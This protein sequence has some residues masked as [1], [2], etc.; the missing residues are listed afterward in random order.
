M[1]H[2]LQ[3]EQQFAPGGIAHIAAHPP[4]RDQ[5]LATC[6][7][8]DAMQGRCRICDDAAGR[9][10]ERLLAGGG[11]DDQLAAVVLLRGGKKQR[12]G[13]VGAGAGDQDIV[14]MGAVAVAARI[15]A[16][17]CPRTGRRRRTRS[18][19]SRSRA[20]ASGSCRARRLRGQ[21]RSDLADVTHGACEHKALQWRPDLELGNRESLATRRLPE[22][23]RV[24]ALIGRSGEI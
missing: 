21:Y 5:T 19:R 11:I 24:L 9:Q 17:G 18:G 6:D 7:R 2:G 16:R 3:I 15:W 20:A 22:L 10:L 12:E 1:T 23:R 4:R 14:N 8:G 13:H